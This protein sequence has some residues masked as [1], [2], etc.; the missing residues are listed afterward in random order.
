MDGEDAGQP[1]PLAKRRV[2]YFLSPVFAKF[3]DAKN[4]NQPVHRRSTE[5][6]GL[7]V[8]PVAL[9]VGNGLRNSCI[10][11]RQAESSRAAR[12]VEG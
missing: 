10:V 7:C 2:R 11:G 5:E 1:K 6:L 8:D 3:Q 9:R 12:V 4:R